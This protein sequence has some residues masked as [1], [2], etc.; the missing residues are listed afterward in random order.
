MPSEAMPRGSLA[1]MHNFRAA[2]TL[3]AVLACIVPVA[4]FAVG[5]ASYDVLHVLL[6]VGLVGTFLTT[7]LRLK[8]TIFSLRGGSCGSLRLLRVYSAL[9]LLAMGTLY[10]ANLHLLGNDFK[11]HK[12]QGVLQILGL[13][14]PT[15]EDIFSFTLLLALV[16][17][18][19]NF[20]V[21]IFSISSMYNLITNALRSSAGY[22]PKC[23]IRP[24]SNTA[25]TVFST[26]KQ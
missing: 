16:R 20:C 7:T 21:F 13:W 15:L 3:E 5:A 22:W 14:H 25:T 18:L 26:R 12:Y 8:P 17:L 23:G 4:I 9:L 2:Q 6:L 1:S 11:P 24:S 19:I 10:L